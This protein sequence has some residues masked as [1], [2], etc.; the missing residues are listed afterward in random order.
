M[1]ILHRFYSIDWFD[2]LSRK[3]PLSPEQKSTI[4]QLNPGNALIFSPRHRLSAYSDNRNF[5]EVA[6]RNRLTE[7]YGASKTNA[8][9][10]QITI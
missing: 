10:D 5:F 7:D 8:I 2:Y 4:V 1:A 6:I 9:I 3:I